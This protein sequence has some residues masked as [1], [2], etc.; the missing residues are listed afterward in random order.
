MEAPTPARNASRLGCAATLR[1]QAAY[2]VGPTSYTL[3]PT[4]HVLHPTPYTLQPATCNLQ[5]TPYTLHPT[6]YNLQPTPYTLSEPQSA[7]RSWRPCR[8]WRTRSCSKPCQAAAA[9]HQRWLPSPLHGVPILRALGLATTAI[10]RGDGAGEWGGRRREGRAGGLQGERL[11]RAGRLRVSVLT[12]RRF[13]H[14]GLL[15]RETAVATAV[16]H[17]S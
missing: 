2:E 4:P 8:S 13:L 5:P 15:E 14:K 9:D 16:A 11:Q 10:V 17:I 6:P 1:P 7:T 3:H 12:T